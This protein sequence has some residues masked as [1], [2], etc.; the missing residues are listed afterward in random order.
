MK[1]KLIV[2]IAACLLLNIAFAQQADP[3]EQFNRDTYRMNKTLDKALVK[4]VAQ[5]YDAIAPVPL[6]MGVSNFFSNLGEV[7]SVANATLQFKFKHAITGTMRFLINSTVGVLGLVDVATRLGLPAHYEDF[8]LTL[9]H[10]GWKDSS[11]LVLPL[12]GPTT[13]RDALGRP[14]N[15]YGTLYPYLYPQ[16]LRFLLPGLSGINIRASLLD[17]ESAAKQASFDEYRFIRNAY[18]QKR[19]A[20][21]NNIIEGE[22]EDNDIYIEADE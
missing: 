21:I 4:P 6:K 16:R 12:L 14:V 9:A 13:V 22:I 15:Y 17:G 19:N 20:Q 8:G 5:V 11:Y 18:L 3:Y 2:L 10:W 7:P 1:S